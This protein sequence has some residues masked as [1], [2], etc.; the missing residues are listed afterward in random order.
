MTTDLLICGLGPAGRAIAHRG[1]ARGLTVTVVDPAPRRTWTATY[2]A[3]AD[4]LPHWLVSDVVATTISRPMVWGTQAHVVDR[5]YAVLDTGRLQSSLSVDGA[6]VIT[7]HAVEIAHERVILASGT[8][9]TA[10]RV[11]DARGLARSPRRAEQTAYGL[12]VDTGRAAGLDPLFM[13]WRADNGAPADAA[14]SFLYAVPLGDGRMLLEETC[15]AGKPALSGT[16]LRARLRHRLRSRGIR[17]T[18]T[19]TVEHVRFPVQGGRPGRDRFG[20]AGG[21][22]HPATGYS[23]GAALTSA[24]AMVA[25]LRIWPAQ[26]RAVQ[27]LREAGL[28]ALLALPPEDIPL[29]FDTFFTLPAA[30]QRAYLSGRTDLGGTVT[31]M[32]LLFEALPWRLR[33]RIASATLGITV[34]SH[35]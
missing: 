31:A 2:A 34:R 9:L 8:E 6:R 21:F 20:A 5:P 7:D 30:A 11:I 19:E 4:E 24:D 22:L 23:V 1:L 10:G 17:L 29:F 27:R 3:W 28:R 26:A 35:R 32:R 15:L 18:G 33:R 13:D 25:G 12:I 14:R 16:C